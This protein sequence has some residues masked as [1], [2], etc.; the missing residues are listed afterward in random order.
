M[1][2]AVTNGKFVS[3]ATAAAILTSNLNYSQKRTTVKLN[4]NKITEAKKHSLWI[5]LK[6]KTQ[7]FMFILLKSKKQLNSFIKIIFWNNKERCYKDPFFWG[8]GGN[9]LQKGLRKLM[10]QR[11]LSQ[12]NQNKKWW[13]FFI[14]S[15]M[16]VVFRTTHITNDKTTE[17][18]KLIQP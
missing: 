18:I 14:I 2:S 12:R 6:K 11:E 16:I 13:F 1:F 5:I 10:K 3:S 17:E 7:D 8:V 4:M 9:Y 15:L